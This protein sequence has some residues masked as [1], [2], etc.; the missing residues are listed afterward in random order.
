MLATLPRKKWD[1]FTYAALTGF[2]AALPSAIEA[3]YNAAQ[4][5]EFSVHAFELVQVLIAA[6][7]FVWFMV[8]VYG[9][10]SEQT[11]AEL[12][13]ELCGKEDA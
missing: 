1:E 13:K 3:V 12:L 2:I 11:A 6:G 4:R 7:F 9:G 8:K 5:S 10:S